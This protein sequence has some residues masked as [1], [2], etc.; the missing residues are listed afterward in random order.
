V[1]DLSGTF[2]RFAPLARD[3]R[4]FASLLSTRRQNIQRAIHNLNL[5]AG[6]LGSVDSQLASLIRSSNTNFSAIASQDTNLRTALSLLPPTLQQTSQTLGKV[7]A[8]ANASGPALQSLLPFARALGPALAA[9][10]PLFRDTTP[11]VQNQLRPFSVAV[12]PL[13][14]ILSPGATAL[15]R[16]VPPL[17]KSFAV[18]NALFNTLAYQ[19]RGSEQGY[20]F[21]G[22]WLSHIAA[23]LTATQDAH[24]PIVRGLFTGTCAELAFF[25]FQLQPNSIPLGVLIDLLNPPAVSKL[26][27]VTPTPGIPGQF[28]CPAG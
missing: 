11:V 20:L 5:V 19:P 28:T 25:E 6:S 21:W 24:G 17:S 15:A 26:P 27:G 12:Q 22:A 18:L 1:A 8:F 13:A 23:S 9:S 16:A 10:R 2:K 4:T 3:T 14:R 7:Q